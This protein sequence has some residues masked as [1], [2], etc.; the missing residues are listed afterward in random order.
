MSDDT[1]LPDGV[2]ESERGA[3]DAYV[4]NVGVDY[5]DY[6]DFRDSFAGEYSSI[7]DYAEEVTTDCYDVPTYL[8]Y[9]IDWDSMARDWELSGDIWTERSDSGYT[10]YVFRCV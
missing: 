4:S 3:W 2:D 1:Q 10:V 8:E 5:V 6:D 7:A 9:Y